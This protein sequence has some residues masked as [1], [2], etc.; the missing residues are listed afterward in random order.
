MGEKETV[1][2]L[3]PL[4]KGTWMTA[5]A[6]SIREHFICVGLFVPVGAG[7]DTDGC[8]QPAVLLLP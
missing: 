8:F 1:Y 7:S 3:F 5:T 4:S 2:S 6:C